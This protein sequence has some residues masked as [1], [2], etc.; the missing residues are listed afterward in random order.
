MNKL[1]ISIIIIFLAGCETSKPTPPP[2][3]FQP[4]TIINT[5]DNQYDS[6]W[7]AYQNLK[8]ANDLTICRVASDDESSTAS[9]TAASLIRN[10]RKLDCDYLLRNTLLPSSNEQTSRV[11]AAN[12][13]QQN[14][15][16]TT[17]SP[18]QQ[19]EQI[20]FFEK[21]REFI[22][23]PEV[24]QALASGFNGMSM[25]PN[26]Y[27]GGSSNSSMPAN[28]SLDNSTPQVGVGFLDRETVSGQNKTC[29]YNTVRG[30]VAVTQRATSLCP[31]SPRV[32]TSNQTSLNKN[33]SPRG[34]L[35]GETRDGLNK[36]CHYSG[37]Q[38]DFAITQS[39]TEICSLSTEQQ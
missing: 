39:N 23:N 31:L 9:S 5:Q 28:N 12:T 32:T 33:S 21:L 13:I 7:E 36:I 11:S 38:G 2:S 15:K 30:E 22:T 27:I 24:L 4:L 14:E 37:V 10:N 29:Y 16:S 19:N 6:S 1:F 3:A 26:P 18:I 35:K 8:M 20:G 25:N 34:F 17:A